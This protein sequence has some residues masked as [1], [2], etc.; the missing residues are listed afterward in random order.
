MLTDTQMVCFEEAAREFASP[1]TSSPSQLCMAS[2]TAS[3]IQDVEDCL[4]S[5]CSPAD[6]LGRK[7][8][9]FSVISCSYLT[10]LFPVDTIRTLS[11]VCQWPARSRKASLVALFA[12]QV[13]AVICLALRLFG[14][15]KQAIWFAVDDYLVLVLT[16]RGVESS[17]IHCTKDC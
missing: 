12:I 10:H 7:S 15:M 4:L 1:I 16:V 8:L 11:Q 3:L 13:P 14:R 5:H 6:T 17:S 2:Q 9:P